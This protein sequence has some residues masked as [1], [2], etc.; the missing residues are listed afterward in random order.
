MCAKLQST[1]WWLVWRDS[2][3]EVQRKAKGCKWRHRKSAGW[4]CWVLS[5]LPSTKH[6]SLCPLSSV[7]WALASFIRRKNLS[8]GKRLWW[9]KANGDTGSQLVGVLSVEHLAKHQ[10][11]QPLH[12]PVSIEHWS[13]FRKKGSMQL[14]WWWW[15]S[16]VELCSGKK[17]YGVAHFPSLSPRLFHTI[18]DT[19]WLRPILLLFNNRNVI[20]L[21]KQVSPIDKSFLRILQLKCF[22]CHKYQH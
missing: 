2:G 13:V 8:R 4:K 20:W 21:T 19:I 1:H 15:C 3:E 12:W 7:H 22:E 18:I 16:V 5:I 6:F 11:L 9:R 14:Q 17:L 10:P